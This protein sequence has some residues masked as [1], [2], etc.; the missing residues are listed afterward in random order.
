[1]T[2]PYTADGG[3]DASFGHAFFRRDLGPE[4]G[5]MGTRVTK[6]A[7]PRIDEWQDTGVAQVTDPVGDAGAPL[8]GADLTNLKMAFRPDYRDLYLKLEIEG[9]PTIDPVVVY[10]VRFSTTSGRFELRITS[11]AS[12]IFQLFHCHDSWTS[13]HESASVQGGF[14]TTGTSAVVALPLRALGFED[15]G[16]IRRIGAFSAIRMPLGR[17]LTIDNI[18]A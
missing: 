16:I 7:A 10:G 12:S 17:L 8:S 14:G 6:P 2:T 18:K 4:I 15:G 5:S 3:A 1:F 13:C 11:D 9:F